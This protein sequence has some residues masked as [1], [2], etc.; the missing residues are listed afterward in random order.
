MEKIVF[1]DTN[2]FVGNKFSF[3]N[4]SLTKLKKYVENNVIIMLEN[5]ITKKEI[6]KHMYKKVKS[7]VD[8][9]NKICEE[10]PI[11]ERDELN[12][13]EI[14]K[15]YKEKLEELFI[16]SIKLSLDIDIEEIIDQHF[17]LIPPFEKEKAKEFK[18]AFVIQLLKKYKKES[19]EEIFIV[20]NDRGFQKAFNNVEGFFI[21]NSISE[22]IDKIEIEMLEKNEKYIIESI[23]N[24]EFD[25]KVKDFILENINFDRYSDSS[26][27]TIEDIEL[28]RFCYELIEV[29]EN[30]SIKSFDFNLKLRLK[31]IFCYLDED[32]SYFDREDGEYLF[33]NYIKTREIHDVELSLVINCEAEDIKTKD[34]EEEFYL[35]GY[36]EIDKEKTDK[37]IYL[38]ED[39]FVEE[40]VINNT[41]NYF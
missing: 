34:M 9:Y 27:S 20:T 40:E 4:K 36:I 22:L 41:Y 26:D 33:S 23:K 10:N 39:S 29:L 30:D 15:K 35:D 37:S 7:I 25:D 19:K 1:L 16:N 24:G 14:E 28:E 38:D 13:K 18:D 3:L 8:D 5:E 2:V 12:E 21:F 17:N 6:Y 32:T 11:I 31:I